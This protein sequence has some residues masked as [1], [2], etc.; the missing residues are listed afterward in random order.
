M[1]SVAMSAPQMEQP[2][3]LIYGRPGG[4]PPKINQ[5]FE[6]GSVAAKRWAKQ[7]TLA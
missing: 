4:T 1:A 3:P 7:G 6:V 5:L 2:N